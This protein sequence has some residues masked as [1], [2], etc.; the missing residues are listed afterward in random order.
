M[1]LAVRYD[2]GTDADV[3]A[4]AAREG[5]GIEGRDVGAFRRGKTTCAGR[6]R[7]RRRE[8]AGNGE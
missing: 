7:S 5:V 8:V 3:E 4:L 2:G 6:A 1:G